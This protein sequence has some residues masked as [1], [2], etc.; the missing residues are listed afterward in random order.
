MNRTK[1]EWTDMSWNPV[2]GCL[3]DCEYCYARAISSRFKR[4]FEPEFHEKRIRQPLKENKSKRIF[5]CSMADLFGDWVDH[6]WI[7][8]VLHICKLSK[9]HTFQFLTKNPDRLLEFE[10]PDNCWIGCTAVDQEMY[11]KASV[12]LSQFDKQITFLSCEPLL[13]EIELDWLPDWLIVGACSNPKPSQPDKEW[14]LNMVNYAKLNKIPVFLKPNLKVF[15]HSLFKEFPA[16][17]YIEAQ[18]TLF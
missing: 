8:R 16:S 18:A 11:D 12:V 17:Q 2:T 14:V 7:E 10:F 4:S 3:H 6:E 9:Q 1:I 5:V 13:G 15:N